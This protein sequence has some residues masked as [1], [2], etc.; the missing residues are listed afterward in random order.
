MIL[1]R[2]DRRAERRSFRSPEMLPYE[3]S[4]PHIHTRS[5][6]SPLR[7]PMR[8]YCDN[9]DARDKEIRLRPAPSGA[10]LGSRFCLWRYCIQW[11]VFFLGATHQFLIRGFGPNLFP[12][13]LFISGHAVLVRFP[14]KRL[15][16]RWGLPLM[17]INASSV[18]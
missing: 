10:I 18:L 3:Q 1:C 16:F 15:T 6:H 5:I 13:A 9:L 14:S 12:P 8:P 7:L 17:R 2:A 4:I 11:F